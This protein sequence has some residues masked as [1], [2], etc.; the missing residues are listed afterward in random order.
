MTGCPCTCI[1]VALVAFFL[2]IF[3]RQQQQIPAGIPS[4]RRRASRG[5]PSPYSWASAK[6]QQGAY[7]SDFSSSVCQ[8]TICSNFDPKARK[9]CPCLQFRTLLSFQRVCRSYVALQR[10]CSPHESPI[11]P[12][13][14]VCNRPENQHRHFRTSG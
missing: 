6:H 4:S 8:K 10:H 13:M 1:M 12:N 9:L 11:H 14:D 5:F 7:E 2:K 3:F